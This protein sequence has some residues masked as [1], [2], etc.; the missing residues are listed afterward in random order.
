[1]VGPKIVGSEKFLDPRFNNVQMR[2]KSVVMCNDCLGGYKR[3]EIEV[4]FK[5]IDNLRNKQL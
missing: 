1:M 5:D 3:G 4:S 2:L